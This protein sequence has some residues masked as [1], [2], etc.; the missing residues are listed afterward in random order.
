MGNRIGLDDRGRRNQVSTTTLTAEMIHVLDHLVA[1]TYCFG[2]DP[3]PKQGSIGPA[4]EA[5]VAEG[6]K[7]GSIPVL[8]L[9]AQ[10]AQYHRDKGITEWMILNPPGWN[11][12]MAY[13]GVRQIAQ[14]TDTDRSQVP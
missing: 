3:S 6:V 13:Q 10:H 12:S 1:E 8:E 14:L 4:H 11:P 9:C 2:N 7:I 5:L